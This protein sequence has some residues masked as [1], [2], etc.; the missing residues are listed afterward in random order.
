MDSGAG[1]D[2]ESAGRIFDPFF[3]TKEKGSGIGLALSKRYVESFGGKLEYEGRSPLGGAAFSIA[4]G[5]EK[6]P[7]A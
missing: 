1:I 7:P 4:M 3:T 2:S 6:A 5:Q